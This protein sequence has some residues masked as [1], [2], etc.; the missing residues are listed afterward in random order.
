VA[1]PKIEPGK[2][3]LDPAEAANEQESAR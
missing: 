2:E 1:E 3:T